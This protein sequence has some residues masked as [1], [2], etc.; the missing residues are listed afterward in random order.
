MTHSQHDIDAIARIIEERC[1]Q[2]MF[3]GLRGRKIAARKILDHFAEDME[4]LKA[5]RGFAADTLDE[6]PGSP[7]STR[8]VSAQKNGLLK[9]HMSAQQIRGTH[10]QFWRLEKT[11]RLR[12]CREKG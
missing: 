5:L 12:R 9:L 3:G 8:A 7:G 2:D 11:D 1:W 10:Y 6:L 4:D